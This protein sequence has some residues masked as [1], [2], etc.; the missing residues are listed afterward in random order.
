M[1]QLPLALYVLV[2]VQFVPETPRW[3]LG[4]GRVQEAFDFLVKYH[5]N[6]DP[7]DE[8]VL[9][10]FQEMREAIKREQFAKAERW[11]TILKS[12][13]NRHRLGLAILMT[14]MTNVG[15]RESTLI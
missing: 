13:T 6:G 15:R 3:L 7:T 4:K 11:S 2:A 1:L 14:F 9:F 10:E 5:G 12:R 8:L